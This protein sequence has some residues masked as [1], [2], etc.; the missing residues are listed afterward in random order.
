MR[1]QGLAQRCVE[2]RTSELSACGAALR[3][4]ALSM[5]LLFIASCGGGGGGGM[6]AG[7]GTT[8]N[9]VLQSIDMGPANPTLLPGKTLQLTVTGLY[10]NG[11]T[12]SVSPIQWTSSTTSVA[13]ID[14]NGLVSA[15]L[16]GSS[17][18]TV[19]SGGV[20]T[21]TTVLVVAGTASVSYLY[22]FGL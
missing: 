10:S 22:S 12:G 11:T 14:N 21:S 20:V 15:L 2:S 5:V 16:A 18:I 3:I 6:G 7:G 8:G 1:R 4:H 19:S 13:T 9:V 17:T